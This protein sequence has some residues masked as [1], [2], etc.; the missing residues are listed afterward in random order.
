[1]ALAAS[2]AF[3]PQRV[4]AM[5]PPIRHR[6]LVVR[7][8]TAGVAASRLTIEVEQWL[9]ALG[10]A[11]SHCETTSIDATLGLAETAGAFDAVVAAGGDGT[12]RAL[13]GVVAG[14]GTPLG[15]IPVG[16]G[17]VMAN[18]AGIPSGSEAIAR[19]L[20]GGP[21]IEIE[22]GRVNGADFFLMAGAGLDGAVISRLD[23]AL[24][25]RLGKLAYVEP[26]ISV[27]AQAPRAF[28]VLVDG[29]AY[30]ACWVVAANARH[31]AG[32]FVIAP[33]AS[34]FTPGLHAVLLEPRSRHALAA[35]LAALAAG[36]H[37]RVRG[38]HILPACRIEVPDAQPIEADGDYLGTAPFIVTAGGPRLSLIVPT[39]K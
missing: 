17:N 37:E 12:I 8:P 36:R 26:T 29:T 19:T 15:I 5:M 2:Q 20:A 14:I 4:P 35:A 6:F 32:R 10:C 7:N 22:G 24:K 28:R 18:E 31:Y 21:V 3:A 23:V 33:A 1:M 39:V 30:D 13:A 27:L 34:L 38:L 16:T 9:A 11:V 25:R